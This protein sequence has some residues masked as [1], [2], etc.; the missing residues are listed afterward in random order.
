[1]NGSKVWMKH[2]INKRGRRENK[3][4]SKNFNS[5]IHNEKYWPSKLK[6]DVHWF[7]FDD[8]IICAKTMKRKNNKLLCS[9]L[10]CFSIFSTSF[11]M[12]AHL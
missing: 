2:Q 10:K 3:I 11:K 9:L 6:E 5:N 1:M 12:K 8:V 4:S 7:D